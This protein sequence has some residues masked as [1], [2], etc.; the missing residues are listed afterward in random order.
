MASE[1][2]S[3]QA[4]L[5]RPVGTG[6]LVHGR[7]RA[8]GLALSGATPGASSTAFAALP[9]GGTNRWQAGSAATAK[10]AGIEAAGACTAG[11]AFAA[12]TA[13]SA[14]A[15]FAGA[16]AATAVAAGGAVA[17]DAAL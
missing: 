10:C 16:G 11:A 15:G 4:R 7:W 12:A 14:D 13:G 9:A 1:A 6:Q 2:D 17:A 8:A 3:L 5:A